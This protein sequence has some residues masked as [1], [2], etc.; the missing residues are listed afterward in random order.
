MTRA[1]D[2]GR[3]RG[4][5]I[6]VESRHAIRQSKCRMAVIRTVLLTLAMIASSHAGTAVRAATIGHAGIRAAH[7][8]VVTMNESAVIPV[9]G[10]TRGVAGSHFRT[11]LHL[12]NAT[13]ELMEGEILFIDPSLPPYPYSIPARSTRFVDDLLPETFEGLTSAE[14]RRT[15]G[16]LPVAIA[17]VFNDDPAGGTTGVVERAIPFRSAL[18]P[19]DRATLL[20]PAD[21][22]ATRFNVG[23][24]SLAAGLAVRV[25]HRNSA[26]GLINVFDRSLLPSSLV[27]EPFATFTGAAAG[28]TDS[29]TFHV[30]A[31]GGVVYGAATDNGTNDPNVQIAEAQETPHSGRYIL[32]VAGSVAGAFDS[33]FATALQMYNGSDDLLTATLRFH[34]AGVSG[35]EADPGVVIRIPA[36]GSAIS[37]NIVRAIGAD[38]LGSLDLSVAGTRD[39]VMLARIYNV[40]GGGET[41]L[42]SRLIPEEEALGATDVAVVVAPAEPL[43]M[44]FN[45]GMR[46]LAEGVRMTATVRRADGEVIRVVPIVLPGTYFIQRPAQELLGIDALHGSESVTFAIE[47]GAAIVYGVWTDNVTQDPAVQYAV[48]P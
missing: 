34:A 11:T 21:P 3:Q 27:H 32:P 29:L 26:R 24:R 1:A 46:T 16:A 35:S 45:I 41:S 37:S 13:G 38:G 19:G 9:I 44:R 30:L 18:E 28:T 22:V 20:V 36:H 15:S 14:V 23:L 8:R 10:N 33:Q 43:R 31:G 42:M 2:H 5:G 39:P 48:T 7:E 12:V 4:C 17:H 25:E 6:T 47:S 40:A